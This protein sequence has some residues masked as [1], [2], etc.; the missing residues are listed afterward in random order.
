MSGAFYV[1]VGA[2]ADKENAYKLA[3]ILT[4]AGHK[5][6]LE[7][8]NN[9][10][11]NVQGRPVV[12]LLRRAED[13]ESVQGAL[14]RRVCGR[15]KLRPEPLNPGFT[16]PDQK[17]KPLK[18]RPVT[19]CVT[20]HSHELPTLS[21]VMSAKYVA[22]SFCRI[23]RKIAT[24]KLRFSACPPLRGANRPCRAASVVISMN[25][26]D[27]TPGS[28]R[29]KTSSAK[30]CIFSNNKAQQTN[31]A[32]PVS[33]AHAVNFSF[34]TRCTDKAALLPGSLL[35]ETLREG[36]Q[37]PDHKRRKSGGKNARQNHGQT[38]HGPL[39]LTFLQGCRSSLG[40]GNGPQGQSSG[41]GRRDARQI[42][43]PDAQQRSQGS[44]WATTKAAAREGM[45]S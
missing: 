6:R 2:F 45:P 24:R 36:I 20:A 35:K 10:R 26:E 21:S 34:A 3:R 18:Q 15:G 25:F 22:S 44:G 42:Q 23:P 12:G 28:A 33:T 4:R 7:F 16:P 14:S 17:E 8:G 11:W 32:K 41:K 19:P 31:R 30:S 5:G 9:N 38:A 37:Q 13:A 29:S 27:A 1:Q 39:F 40:M 43:H